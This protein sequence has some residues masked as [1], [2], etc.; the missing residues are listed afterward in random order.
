MKFSISVPASSS[1]IGPG[2]DTL[3]LAFTL[4]NRFDFEI[5]D[6]PGTPMIAG[7]DNLIYRSFIHTMK[8][9]F[10]DTVERGF[11]LNISTQI[12]ISSGLGSSASCIVAGVVAAFV[13]AGVEPD[14]NEIFNISSVLEDHPDNASAAVFGG[15]TVSVKDSGSERYI[16]SIHKVPDNFK[17]C[18]V[19]A[20]FRIATDESRSKLPKEY[21]RNAAVYNISHASMTVA[22]FLTGDY[23]LLRHSCDD[24][25]HQPYRFPAI[26]D[27]ASI[28]SLCRSAGADVVFLSG[29]GPTLIAVL[30]SNPVEFADKVEESLKY[31]NNSWKTMILTPDHDGYKLII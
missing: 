13:A 24:L 2:F 25:M 7:A 29:S 11:K 10:K 31:F 26:P 12:P 17:F 1:N 16:S 27:S 20:E 21:S 18:A 22:A 9:H 15:F 3:G 8:N 14:R 4:C 23:A 19:M 28:I 5:S 6:V 30:E